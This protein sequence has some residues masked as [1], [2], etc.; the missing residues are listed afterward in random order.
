MFITQNLED[1]F[2]EIIQN[3]IKKIE[4]NIIWFISTI[5]EAALTIGRA[6]YSSMIILG[7]ILW[8]MNLQK[9]YA[10]RLIYGGIILA[11]IVELLS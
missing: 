9:Y 2:R 1:Q 3:W 4:E 10:K 7:I 6:S 8:C 5:K 11:L